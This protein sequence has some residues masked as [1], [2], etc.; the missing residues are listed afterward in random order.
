[1]MGEPSVSGFLLELARMFFIVGGQV[2]CILVAVWA[3]DK[4]FIR[5]EA[6]DEHE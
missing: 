5:E 2:A 6:N 1:M 4:L 3:Y